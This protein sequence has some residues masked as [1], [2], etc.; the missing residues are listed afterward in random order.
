MIRAIRKKCGG[1]YLCNILMV[2]RRV[3]RFAVISSEPGRFLRRKPGEKCAYFREYFA[4][5]K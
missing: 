1:K 4:P 5:E 3:R 2:W